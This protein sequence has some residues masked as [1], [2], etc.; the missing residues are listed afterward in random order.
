MR[1]V[2]R[3]ICPIAKST[4]SQRPNCSYNNGGMHCTCTKRP[5]FH[6]HS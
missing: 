4:A 2:E 3:G 5:Y 1:S 6:F